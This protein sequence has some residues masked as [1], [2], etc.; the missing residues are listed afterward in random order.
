MIVLVQPIAN[1]LGRIGVPV[2]VAVCPLLAHLLQADDIDIEV[3]DRPGDLSELRV[4][5][6]LLIAVQVEREDFQP[7]AAGKVVAAKVVV[8]DRPAR[9]IAGDRVLNAK[10]IVD[11]DLA[12]PNACIISIRVPGAAPAPLVPVH[13]VE[14]ARRNLRA[15]P[16][17]CRP[18][19]EHV[20]GLQGLAYGDRD[21]IVLL[22]VL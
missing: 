4:L 22:P 6:F 3:V 8:P 19:N 18:V 1:N 10:C 15:A 13:P 20:L 16:V 12:D 14:K 11:L 7:A 21:W 9:R 2:S 17:V 5:I